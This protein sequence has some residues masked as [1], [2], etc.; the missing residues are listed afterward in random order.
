MDIPL[1]A[2]DWVGVIV[3]IIFLLVSAASAISNMAKEKN[4]AQPGKVK[5]K[6]ALQKELEKFLQEAMNPQPKKK[7]KPAEVDF[8]EETDLEP[9]ASVQQQPQRRR[10]QQRKSQPQRARSQQTQKPAVRSNEASEPKPHLSHRERAE[11]KAQE[12]EKRM[13]GG[14]RDRIEKKQQSHVETRL[15]S[16]LESKV[17]KHFSETTDSHAD[18]S[19]QR[20]S[21]TGGSKAIRSLL[22]DPQS[23]RQAIILNE[24]LSPPLSRRH[25]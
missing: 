4:K 24:I 21:K 12:Q 1:L 23:F 6:A 20:A 19:R 3:G 10:R 2:A 8:F 16:H 7:E 11:I 14:V 22:R 13:R 9:Q 15:T 18:E 17:G 5:E 25:S